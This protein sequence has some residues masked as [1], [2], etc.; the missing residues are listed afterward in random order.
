MQNTLIYCLLFFSVFGLFK[1][2]AYNRNNVLVNISS[3]INEYHNC[4]NFVFIYDPLH[5]EYY[6]VLVP[7]VISTSKEN[8]DEFQWEQPIIT[9][10]VKCVAAFYIF[11]ERSQH[12]GGYRPS[13][14]LLNGDAKQDIRMDSLP[15]TGHIFTQ[16]LMSMQVEFGEVRWYNDFITFILHEIESALTSDNIL[17]IKTTYLRFG[18]DF[19]NF[20]SVELNNEK[21]SRSTIE[22]TFSKLYK[23]GKYYHFNFPNVNTSISL[24][25][26]IHK[27]MPDP[28]T[29]NRSAVVGDFDSIVKY[30]CLET[31]DVW[32]SRSQSIDYGKSR[33]NSL[34]YL[35][36]GVRNYKYY[37]TSNEYL[38]ALIPVGIDFHNF[39]TCDGVSK[40]I[41]F[42]FYAKPYDTTFWV[43]FL[44]SVFL[45][46][47]LALVILQYAHTLGRKLDFVGVMVRFLVSTTLEV[48][49]TIP[50]TYE[51]KFQD[52]TKLTLGLWLLVIVILTNAYKGIIVSDLTSPPKQTRKWTSVSQTKNFTYVTSGLTKRTFENIDKN[53]LGNYERVDLHGVRGCHCFQD[54]QEFI[55]SVCKIFRRP[56]YGCQNA[57][58]ELVS[59]G[60]DLPS[61]NNFC[62][63]TKVLNTYLEIYNKDKFNNIFSNYNLDING[64]REASSQFC[65]KEFAIRATKGNVSKSFWKLLPFANAIMIT[66]N[67]NKKHLEFED[68]N[69][70]TSNCYKTGYIDYDSILDVFLATSRLNNTYPY[71]HK[72]DE[73]LIPMWNAYAIDANIRHYGGSQLYGGF[74]I[75]L[76]SGI[77]WVWEKWYQIKYPSEGQKIMKSYQRLLLD[78]T[79]PQVLNLHSNISTIFLILIFC[80]LI[81]IL[82]FIF[83]SKK[84]W[85]K[86]FEI[87]IRFTVQFLVQ[88]SRNIHKV[89]LL[90]V[91][92]L[93]NCTK[94]PSVLKTNVIRVFNWLHKTW[95]WRC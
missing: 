4:F 74:Q 1:S 78:R 79:L 3:L 39:V 9:K 36:D 19:N 77:Y 72:G 81:T 63:E 7:M 69:N 37:W 70:I 2:A 87:R 65:D 18:F 44:T 93:Q 35:V 50:V 38:S 20:V 12:D 30:L 34:R 26:L 56:W 16:E 8:K 76:A 46:L 67:H 89:L 14:I 91:K 82:V 22:H 58:G 48:S 47:P 61:N 21:S 59:L 17:N 85:Y 80:I 55:N 13:F 6:P 75:L 27:S 41:S 52:G 57:S 28:F 95:N 66:P 15:T 32:I 64:W 31:L 40:P 51:Q 92:V 62:E 25:K 53:L 43:I 60:I 42:K 90:Q 29:F 10:Y 88:G 24:R 73:Q 68:F 5:T 86:L 71:Y 33:S 49:P 23:N 11:P 54:N 84:L 83:E 45:T 94:L